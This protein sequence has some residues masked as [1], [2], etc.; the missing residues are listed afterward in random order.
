MRFAF[1]IL[2]YTKNKSKHRQAKHPETVLSYFQSLT[3]LLKMV[4][5][6]SFTDAAFGP[7]V[8][9]TSKRN[10]YQT[11]KRFD[12]CWQHQNSKEKRFF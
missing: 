9:Q 3:E 10:R 12:S 2:F 5:M 11:E 1:N 6:T 8:G 7:E 4:M